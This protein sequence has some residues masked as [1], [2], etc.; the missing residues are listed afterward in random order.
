MK[1]VFVSGCYDILH[2]GHIQFFNDARKL[3]DQLIVCIPTDEVYAVYKGRHPALPLVHRLTVMEALRMVDR[4]VLG[5]DA[6]N[7][8]L[9][10]K[11]VFL[12][13]RPNILAVTDDD[14]FE[15][16]KR[17]LCATTGAE[18]VKLPKTAPFRPISSSEIR[19]RIYEREENRTGSSPV[20]SASS[21][22]AVLGE[23]A[24]QSR[25]AAW[26]HYTI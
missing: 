7:P 20:S 19:R 3:G 21:A 14:Q 11:E 23:V 10:F 18:Y 13:I 25:D 2:A 12:G 6:S 24:A 8:A 1:T 22:P 17:E 16:L 9:N 15:Q 4:V 26:Q 5:S